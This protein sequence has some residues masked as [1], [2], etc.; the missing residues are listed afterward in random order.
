MTLASAVELTRADGTCRVTLSGEIDAANAHQVSDLACAVIEDC[1]CGAVVID[2]S[3][4]TFIDSTGL[5]ALVRIRN[6]GLAR[7]LHTTATGADDRI[8]RVFVLT[9]LDTVFGMA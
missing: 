8:M 1:D 7:G 2:L 3:A 5:G 9:A 6:A 4:V